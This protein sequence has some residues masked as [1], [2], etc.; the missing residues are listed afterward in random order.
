MNSGQLTLFAADSPVSRG[1]SPESA[2]ARRMTATSG[3]K[4]LELSLPRGPLGS[5]ARTLLASDQWRSEE[6][7]LAWKA[8]QVVERRMVSTTR[9]Y[10]YE[11]ST[12]SSAV[13][14]TTSIRSVTRSSY[15]KFRLVPSMP[16]TR[17]RDSGL[18]P[19]AQEQDGRLQGGLKSRQNG[20][21][22][23]LPAAVKLWPTA[24]SNDDNKTPEAH[25]AMKR[26]MGERDGSNANRT[27]ITSLQVMAKAVALPLWS[28][29]RATDGA[30][31]GPNMSFGAGG[32][33][34]PSQAA[35]WHTP[36]AI[37][38][39]H[40]GMK[41]ET[42]LTGQAHS[43]RAPNGSPGGA[44]NPEFVCWL[45]G[46]PDGWTSLEPSATPSCRRSSSG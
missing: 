39:E 6:C 36:R 23:T 12:C 46:F 28:T 4:C 13:S 26:R 44:L 24:T 32:R 21:Q 19:T 17:D 27:A 8:E 7:R 5:L 10:I 20:A 30:K 40:P 25:L 37:Y 29:P 45:M 34:L 22:M 31:G 18:W 16:R 43:G 14:A 11:R 9:R 1:P 35:M 15:L 2:E 3:L 38:G 33:P 41:D 42:H